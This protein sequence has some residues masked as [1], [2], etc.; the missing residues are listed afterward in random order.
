MRCHSPSLICAG[1]RNQQPNRMRA[2]LQPFIFDVLIH[3]CDVAGYFLDEP[4]S[5]EAQARSASSDGKA[6]P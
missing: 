1:K 4:T 6:I 3:E 2:V 5:L